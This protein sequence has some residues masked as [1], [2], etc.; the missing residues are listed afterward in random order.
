ME[1]IRKLIENNQTE[2]AIR[3]LESVDGLPENEE[4]LLLLGELYY[5]QGRSTDALN[6]FNAILRNHPDHAKAK[7]YVEMINDVLD[8]FYKDRLNP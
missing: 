7:A 3:R 2:E 4:A 8:F 1:E 6:R 5:R